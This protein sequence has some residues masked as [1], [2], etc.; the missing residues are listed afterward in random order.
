MTSKGNLCGPD[1]KC[2]EP[3]ECW[4]HFENTMC[5]Y[6]GEGSTSNPTFFCEKR[7]TNIE[8]KHIY[9]TKEKGKQYDPNGNCEPALTINQQRRLNMTTAT[10][11]KVA[12]TTKAVV[13]HPVMIENRWGNVAVFG[14][15][16]VS[17]K[18]IEIFEKCLNL[19]EFGEEEGD[20]GVRSVMF[21]EDGRPDGLQA[22]CVP[23]AG[24][25]VIN[26][27]QVLMGSAEETTEDLE[28]SL[29]ASFHRNLVLDYLHEIH[30]ME[31]FH[32]KGL[33]EDIV[34]DEK[35]EAL[36]EQW[37]MEKLIELAKTTDIEPAHYSESPWLSGQIHEL[38][39]NP[40]KSNWV[41]HQLHM[42]ENNIMY[43]L[44]E[45]KDKNEEL[46]LMSFKGLIHL[47]SG[48]DAN[49]EEW[50]TTVTAEPVA[51]PT[52]ANI[53]PV[54]FDI[55]DLVGDMEML[56]ME[57]DDVIPAAPI[58]AAAPVAPVYNA[59]A[60]VLP[61]APTVPIAVPA[62]A[63]PAAQPAPPA[64]AQQ[65]PAMAT[66]PQTGLTP[67]QTRDV[68]F[69]VFN[70]AYNHIF[71]NCGQLQ[72]SDLGFNN[73]EAVS[74]M[75][76][77]LTPREKA[78]I[79]KMDC[80]DENGRWCPQCDTTTGLRGFIMKNA[81]IPAFKLYINNGGHE[82][83]RLMMPQNPGKKGA[84]GGYSKPAAAARG[85]ARIMYIMDGTDKAPGQGSVF[86]FKCI[87]N[88]WQVC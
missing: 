38:L 47:M 53:D 62:A 57:Q 29:I 67:E 84:D 4:G 59:P 66:L 18:D 68:V 17:K 20:H 31:M 22:Q 8:H 12:E 45:V 10:K 34:G 75:S 13:N 49:S 83:I 60:P 80:L 2:F 69:G 24:A 15:S 16:L 71:T 87:D 14:H 23:D 42:V 6:L 35:I 50:Q 39:T 19:S 28:V 3:G 86:L 65:Q 30:H 70:K 56:E 74:T 26:L 27:Q 73:P 1:E 44:K 7:K 11:A 32:K 5:K 36:A 82:A 64:A 48:D 46:T 43:H 88:K 81:K 61:I 79:V 37:A 76:I 41:D 85:G 33:P 21:R 63:I 77:E 54:G 40:E 78:V 25:I 9:F 52:P 55:N 72:Q 51:E 58:P